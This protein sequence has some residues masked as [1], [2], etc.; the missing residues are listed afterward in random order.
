MWPM[1]LIYVISHFCFS[2]L[3]L[4]LI[5]FFQIT[6]LAHTF[7]EDIENTHGQKQKMGQ[8]ISIIL[9]LREKYCIKALMH[10]LPLAYIHV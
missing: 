6:P 8:I 4:L 5:F 2:S 10:I 1:G 7:I 3:L 9:S